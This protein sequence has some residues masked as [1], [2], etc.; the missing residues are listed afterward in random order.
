MKKALLELDVD[1]MNKVFANVG[2]KWRFNPPAAYH[3]GGA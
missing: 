3:F 2:L 1:N